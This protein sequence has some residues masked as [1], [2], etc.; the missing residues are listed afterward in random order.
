M[1]QVVLV[2]FAALREDDLGIMSRMYR[3]HRKTKGFASV[4]GRDTV[5]EQTF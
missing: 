3:C 1:V 5:A 2:K 4:G